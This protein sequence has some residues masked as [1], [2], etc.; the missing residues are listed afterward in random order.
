VSIAVV[1]VAIGEQY[2]RFLEPWSQAVQQLRTPPDEIIVVTDD[3]EEAEMWVH[4]L[5]GMR[6]I[7]NTTQPQHHPQVAV[8]DAIALTTTEWVCKMDVD[9]VIYPHALDTVQDVDAD[10]YMFGIRLNE[11]NLPAR[12]VTRRD[13]LKTPHNLVFSCSPFRRWVWQRAPYEDMICEDWRFWVDA[14]RNGARFY[15]SPTIDYRYN[16]HGG[17]IT[18]RSDQAYWEDQVR[19]YQQTLTR[20]HDVP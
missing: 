3:V 2:H 18:L 1:C 20:R 17:N 5:P 13:I 14:A 7:Q 16:I 6:L 10:V 11:V 15:T 19:A 12:H 9:D 4:W 8:N